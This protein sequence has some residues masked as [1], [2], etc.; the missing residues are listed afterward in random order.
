MLIGAM[1]FPIHGCKPISDF[2]KPLSYEVKRDFSL[3]YPKPLKGLKNIILIADNKRTEIFDLLGPYYLFSQ[4]KKANVFIV[5][6]QPVP[7]PLFRGLSVLPHH[8]FQSFSGLDLKPDLLIIPNL[9]TIQKEEIDMDIVNFINSQYSHSGTSVLSVCDGAATAALTGIYDN[10]PITAHSSDIAVLTEQYPELNWV[11]NKH[12]TQSN[13]LYSTAGVANAT[14]G[15]LLVVKNMFGTARAQELAEQI[16]FPYQLDSLDRKPQYFNFSDKTQIL[17]KVTFKKNKD[18]GFLLTQGISEFL[19]AALLDTYSRTFPK[20]INSFSIDGNPV[21]SM[22]GLILIPTTQEHNFNELHIIGTD[23][24]LKLVKEFKGKII[25]H[26]F[27]DEYIFDYALSAVEN[28]YGLKFRN[29]TQK[30][31][32]Y[33]NH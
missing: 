28:D 3:E 6:K 17:K 9:S 21:R 4:T 24:N 8:T 16:N 26:S 13:S 7:I 30:L 33:G 31:L 27:M 2:Q 29:T 25:T 22:N 15:S 18:L 14:E 19:L 12:V 5:S 11:S 32:D 23:S 1:I 20:E 10:A